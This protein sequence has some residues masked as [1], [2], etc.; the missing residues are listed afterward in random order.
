MT[1][2][3]QAGQRPIPPNSA[4]SA[5][6]K[7]KYGIGIAGFNVPLDISHRSFWGRF[8]GSH[9]QRHHGIEGW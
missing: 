9:D 1:M 8:Y 6:Q 7:V 2:V 5:H 4:K 3:S